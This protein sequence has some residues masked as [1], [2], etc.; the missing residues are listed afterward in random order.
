[1]EYAYS[2]VIGISLLILARISFILEKKLVA[3][4]V[5]FP[6][7]WG[8]AL[9]FVSFTYNFNYF[10]INNFVLILY[11]LGALVFALSSLLT[12]YILNNLYSNGN[13]I[14]CL[15]CLYSVPY[16]FL[17]II[18]TAV[19]FLVTPVMILDIMQY[20]SDFFE[21]SF[22]VRRLV[23]DGESVVSPMV[24]NYLLFSIFFLTIFFTVI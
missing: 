13:N 12:S 8:V 17:L 4:A 18:F 22:K 19:T 23:V 5:A 2:F 15:L 20:G 3:P 10:P 11:F 7:V 14:S 6:L 1:M 9:F 16:K 24:S 21:I